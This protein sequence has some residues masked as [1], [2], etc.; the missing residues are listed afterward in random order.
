MIR[1]L[2]SFLSVIREFGIRRDRDFS[3]NFYVIRDLTLILYVMREFAFF[4]DRDFKQK[5]YGIRDRNLDH[6]KRSFYL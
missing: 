5:V 2:P 3:Q 1:D 4:R 6:E